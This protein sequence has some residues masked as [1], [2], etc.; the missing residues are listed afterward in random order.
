MAAKKARG[1][2]EL[3]VAAVRKMGRVFYRAQLMYSFP[4]EAI[5][6]SYAAQEPLDASYE[7]RTLQEEGSCAAMAA[8][9]NQ[10]PG[11]GVWSEERVQTIRDQ[12][13]SE[14]RAGCVMFRDG[15]P[16]A[17][18]A[19]IKVRENGRTYAEGVY[20][21][22]EPK[23][24]KLKVARYITSFALAAPR[25]PYAPATGGFRDHRPSPPTGHRAL[26]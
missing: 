7:L 21:Y 15:Q 20:L 23:H 17:C 8:L 4:G 6:R 5:E 22:V 10:E 19:V 16:I 9:L 13:I 1:P 3:A 2:V 25:A 14:P 12:L 26:P 11:F 18:G 24:R